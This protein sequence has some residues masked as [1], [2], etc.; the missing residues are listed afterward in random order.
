MDSRYAQLS[1]Q[2]SHVVFAL[3]NTFTDAA[4]PPCA[5]SIAPR[6]SLEGSSLLRAASLAIAV[7]R[8]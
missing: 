7:N 6:L 1:S 4:N 3:P 5:H 2:P 8:Y